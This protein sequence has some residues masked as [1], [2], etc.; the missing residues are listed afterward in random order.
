[1]SATG[2]SDA[3]A[4]AAG[5]GAAPY[6]I[7]PLAGDGSD[8]ERLEAALGALPAITILLEATEATSV[9]TLADLVAKAQ[10]KG[11]ATL[12]AGAADLARVVKAD[13]VHLPASGDIVA[14]Y[15]EAR[16][17]LGQRFIIGADAGRSRHDAM[18]LGE[19]GADYVAF[20]I[21][22]HVADRATARERRHNLVQWWGEIFEV[23]CV[24]FDVD[25]ISDA[26]DLAEAGAD[27]VAIRL[28]LAEPAEI[29]AVARAYRGCLGAGQTVNE[30]GTP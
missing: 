29:A 26:A 7:L 28:P 25:E 2:L 16:E 20:G 5:R 13:G 18:E 12:I 8:A 27:F 19:R 6:L 9:P 3:G 15:E 14:R 10:Q 1:M 11:V 30:K 21:P 23:P 22:Q 4:R 17:S 24:A